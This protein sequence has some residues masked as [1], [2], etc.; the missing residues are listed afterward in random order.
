M[1]C[2][3]CVTIVRDAI[4]GISGVNSVSVS[5]ITGQAVISHS[6]V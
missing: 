2:G 1:H 6:N 5:L 4:R 3:S